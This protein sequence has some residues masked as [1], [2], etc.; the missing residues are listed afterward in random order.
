ME[1]VVEA[2]VLD[3]G[4]LNRFASPWVLIRFKGLFNLSNQKREVRFMKTQVPCR[5]P[6]VLDIRRDMLVMR[7]G[8]L[9]LMLSF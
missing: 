5:S 1:W 2:P 7:V 8:D 4:Y 6:L 9:S 3:D